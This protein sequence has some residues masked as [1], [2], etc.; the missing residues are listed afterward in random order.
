MG[1]PQGSKPIGQHT[2][3]WEHNIKTDLREIKIAELDRI[4]MAKDSD[5]WR[6]LVSAVMS[7]RLPQTAKNLLTK[8]RT[9]TFLSTHLTY[10]Y[11]FTTCLSAHT[12]VYWQSTASTSSRLLHS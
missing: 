10:V 5:E 3:R 11:L 6:A 4:N 8:G 2:H 1:K 9:T 12:G 7:L